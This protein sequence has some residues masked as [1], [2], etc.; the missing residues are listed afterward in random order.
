ML[1]NFICVYHVFAPHWPSSLSVLALFL[2]KSIRKTN[3]KPKI[4]KT[5]KPNALSASCVCT[6]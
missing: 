6:V 3:K 1:G 5:M 2:P 4:T